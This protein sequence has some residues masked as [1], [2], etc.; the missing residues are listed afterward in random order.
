VEALAGAGKPKPQFRKKSKG[1]HKVSDEQEILDQV[2]HD[3][4]FVCAF[5][6]YRHFDVPSSTSISR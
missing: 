1:K 2:A 4:Q 3:E 5:K 6:I